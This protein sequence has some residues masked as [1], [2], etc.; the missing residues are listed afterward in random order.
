MILRTT[1]LALLVLATTVAGAATV[2]YSLPDGVDANKIKLRI[3][4]FTGWSEIANSDALR[5]VFGSIL[6]QTVP[7]RSQIQVTMPNGLDETH[8]AALDAVVLR[9]YADYRR[10]RL[11]EIPGLVE[12]TRTKL[13]TA[14]KHARGVRT[15]MV[16]IFRSGRGVLDRDRALAANAE[17]IEELRRRTVD[18]R[19][20]LA[21]SRALVPGIEKAI[22]DHRT[23]LEVQREE[24]IAKQQKRLDESG[25]GRE[26]PAYADHLARVRKLRREPL[27]DEETEQLS[28]KLADMVVE[29]IS[30]EERIK[31]VTQALADERERGVGI[32][33]A[34]DLTEYR[35]TKVID[36]DQEVSFSKD[37]LRRLEDELKALKSDATPQRISPVKRR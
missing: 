8:R 3:R 7:G 22:L 32:L 13:E 15:A 26:H 21:V 1:I 29:Q 6:A 30:L 27:D 20:E 35:R 4:H 33:E 37:Y 12:A 24:L 9:C 34:I 19:I 11:P 5:S 18:V 36:A 14:V 28:R 23:R 2:S 31:A 16:E 17:R 25:L 10:D